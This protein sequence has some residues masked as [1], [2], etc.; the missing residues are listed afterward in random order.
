MS[1]SDRGPGAKLA[2]L[3]S[4]QQ[5]DDKPAATT[6]A[7]RAQTTPVRRPE[8][9]STP[10]ADKYTKVI[11][12]R[13]TPEMGRALAMAKLDDKI[14]ANARLRGMIDYWMESLPQPDP[15][16]PGQMTPMGRSAKAINERAKKHR[17][18]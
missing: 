8:H 17:Q 3:L 6:R 12:L 13:I 18:Q 2:T 14:D 16:R 11:T 5:A 1:K 10:A 15:E 9:P 4:A 7:R